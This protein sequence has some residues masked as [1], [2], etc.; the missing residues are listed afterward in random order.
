M[1][2][3][4]A[5]MYPKM[6]IRWKSK[7]TKP[8]QAWFRLVSPW[9]LASWTSVETLLGQGHEIGFGALHTG[10]EPEALPFTW[11]PPYCWILLIVECGAEHHCEHSLKMLGWI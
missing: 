11:S 8:K 5:I 6:F 7:R 10:T 9:T 2:H 4:T 3:A 1:L